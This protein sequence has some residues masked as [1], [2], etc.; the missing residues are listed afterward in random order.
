[1]QVYRKI[2]SKKFKIASL[3]S[4]NA[5]KKWYKHNFFM[6]PKNI[7]KEKKVT[8][9]KV[10]VSI[11]PL[12]EEVNRVRVTVG[13]D[14]LEYSRYTYTIL[15]A[16]STI[17]NSTISTLEAYYYTTDTKDFYYSTQ[18]DNPNDYKYTQMPLSFVPDK[19]I[20]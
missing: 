12:K 1:M 2:I 20:K 6:H 8:Y 13:G 18:I 3:R 19:I 4:R 17:I 9:V 16:L 15:V 14:M 5:Y 10:V 7:P 11:I